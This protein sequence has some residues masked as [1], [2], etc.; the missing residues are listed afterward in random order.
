MATSDTHHIAPT[1]RPSFPATYRPGVGIIGCGGIVKAAHLAAYTAYGVN[2]VGV[3]DRL[4]A[5]VDGI[6]ARYPIVGQVFDDVDELFADP[7]VEIVDIATHPMDRCE[8]IEKAIDAGKHVLSQKPFAVDVATARELVDRADQR[9]VR[10]AVNQN[11]RWA[12]AWRVA[13]L[14]IER[15]EIGDI[16]AVTH[17]FEHDFPEAVDTK[18]D[19]I[20]HFL[21]YDFAI[22]WF[23]ITR[24]WFGSKT[25]ESIRAREYRS[26]TQPQGQRQPWG[27][28]VEV[29]YSDGSSAL[30]RSLG[31]PSFRPGDPFWVHG[32]AGAIRGSVRRGTDFVELDQAD[33]LRTFRLA[34]EWLPDG[35]AGTMGELCSA[36]AEDR[37]P[38]NSGRDNI[39]SLQMTL[40]AC[41][42]AD[43]GG[44]PVS[45]H[46]ID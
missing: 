40:A 29:D 44:R 22:H 25:V 19:E 21:L 35:F 11:G 46:E 26:P 8:L 27:G 34:G 30:I 24:V 18:F 12:P 17:M 41:R 23:D 38:T 37:E 43:E 16:C 2:V 28:V 33:G 9:G 7:R 4:P 1:F 31:V 15:G 42:S 39:L 32:S 20:E 14:L 13:T 45:L 10:L 6:Q 3:H 36:V 5:A